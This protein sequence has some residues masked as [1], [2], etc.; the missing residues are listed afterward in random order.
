MKTIF[1]MLARKTKGYIWLLSFL[2]LSILFSIEYLL[3]SYIDL[4]PLYIIV[5]LLASWYGSSKTGISLSIIISAFLLISSSGDELSYFY[6][7]SRIAVIF[8]VNLLVAILVTNFRNVYGFEA[9]AAD[10]DTLTGVHSLR[11]FYAEIANEIL[12]SRRYEHRFS[13]AYI[14]VDDFK[15]INDTLGHHEGDRLLIELA[16]CLTTSLRATDTVARI[17][18]D[19]FVCLMP[20]TEETQAKSAILNVESSLKKR[21]SKK[22]WNVSFSIGL[23]T[24]DTLPEDVH[25]ALKVADELMYSVKKSKKNAIAYKVWKITT[26]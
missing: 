5:V 20:E 2:S 9:E 11:S 26:K 7:N 12:R 23:V 19:E 17:G 3:R 10:T 25:E 15:K 13:L 22:N 21:M 18:G 6:N 14:D 24:F 16:N 1:N 8:V 4:V